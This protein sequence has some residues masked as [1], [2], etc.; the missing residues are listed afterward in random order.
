MLRPSLM[1]LV[2]TR[3]SFYTVSSNDDVLIYQSR[4]IDDIVNKFGIPINARHP[5]MESSNLVTTKAHEYTPVGTSVKF[6]TE[7][8]NQTNF[9]W[10]LKQLKTFF[11]TLRVRGSGRPADIQHV[12]DCKVYMGERALQNLLDDLHPRPG[13]PE[14]VSRLYEKAKKLAGDADI[15]ERVRALLMKRAV[16]GWQPPWNRINDEAT[17]K[18]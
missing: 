14:W 13:D 5:P 7:V 12:I 16:C 10:F 4:C 18:L 11:N 15:D 8:D 9:V 17:V 1:A 3:L 6:S 2:R